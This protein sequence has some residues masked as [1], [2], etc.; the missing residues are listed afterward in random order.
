[1]IPC[2]E[3]KMDM[4]FATK[5]CCYCGI[6]LPIISLLDQK[7]ADVETEDALMELGIIVEINSEP[8]GYNESKCVEEYHIQ[9]FLVNRLFKELSSQYIGY[10]DSHNI[11]FCPYCGINLNLLKN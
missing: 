4:V 11:E 5:F 7:L 6:K 8:I 10:I 3:C 1:M 9:L 2:P